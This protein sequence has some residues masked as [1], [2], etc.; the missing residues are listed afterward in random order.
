MREGSRDSLIY[1]LLLVNRE[2]VH[3]RRGRHPLLFSPDVT[4][5]IQESD[6][7]ITL[8]FQ[9]VLPSLAD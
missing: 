8:I 3:R 2:D 9:C 4:L 1:R 5:F 6:V 7:E